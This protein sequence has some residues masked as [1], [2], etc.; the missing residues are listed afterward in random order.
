MRQLTL[1]FQYVLYN[2]IQHTLKPLYSTV[3][4]NVMLYIKSQLQAQAHK[5]HSGLILGLR[6]ANERRGYKVTLSLIGWAQT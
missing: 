4:Y 2:V 1:P 3:Y 5:A 6:P